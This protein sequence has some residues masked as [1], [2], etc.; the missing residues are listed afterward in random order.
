VVEGWEF[1][2]LIERVIE[3]TD[4]V[5]IIGEHVHLD[6]NHRALCPFHEEKNPSFCV[7]PKNAYFHCFGC[8]V[9]GDVIRF[10]QL[11]EGRTFW[12][13]LSYLA[14]RAGIPLP[15]LDGAV[16]AKMEEALEIEDVLTETA[17][18]Y[19]RMLTPEAR[20][21]LTK[22]R[23][24]TEETIARFR[25][26]YAA[27]GLRRHL[28]GKCAYP[29]E[30]CIRAGV[31]RKTKQGSVTDFFRN[32]II[33]P[34]IRQGRVVHLSG[35]SMDGSEPKYLRLPGQIRH[36]YNEDA[37]HN[38]EVCVVE[39]IVDCL[40]VAQAGLAAVA[41]LG[42]RSFKPE[43]VSKFRQCTRMDF[44]LDGD[45]AGKEGAL[46]AAQ[47]VGDKARIVMLPQGLDPNE[48]LKTHT[49]EDFAGLVSSAKDPV[50]FQLDLISPDTDK[51]ELP[52]R[53]MPVLEQ[54]SRIEKVKAEAHLYHDV[55]TRF[56]LKNRELDGYRELLNRLRGKNEEPARARAPKPAPECLYTALFDGLVDLVDQDGNPAF[57][58]KDGRK[59]SVTTQIEI[60]GVTYQPPPKVQIPWLLPRA[61]GVL[62]SNEAQATDHCRRMDEALYDDLVT[63]HKG[64]SE[65]PAEE[66]YD[67]VAAWVLHTYLLEAFQYSPI[68]CLFAVPERGK[69][70]TGK[71]IIYV[72]YRG[73]HA[74]SLRDAYIIRMAKNCHASIFFDVRNI[75]KK[76][77]KTGTEDILL[78]R[79][80]KGASVPRVLFPDRG[81]H[82]DTV[83]FEIFGPT[84]IGT[85]EEV[86]RILE[87]RAV[88]FY[89][90]EA[91]REYENDV[92]R[93]LSLPLKERLVALRARHLGHV[94]P[95]I[96][97]PAPGR[98]GQILKPLL[99]VIQLVNP[100]REEAFLALV[101]RLQEERLL[102]KADSFEA[103]ILTVME[104]L[105]ED[106]EKGILPVKTITDAFNMGRPERS[107]VTYQ[108]VGKLL[109]PMGFT[110][111]K[112][113]TGASAII[114]DE[115]KIHRIR[116]KYGLIQRSDTSDTSETPVRDAGDT[117]IPDDTDVCRSLF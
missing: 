33:F 25:I 41:V 53:L 34:N 24:L 22:E 23:D 6:R 93:E 108:R 82:K 100:K 64:I 9:G 86:H 61:D 88:P 77:V 116:D 28:T 95:D 13:A 96:H 3:Q 30:L 109:K 32:R 36:L 17:A 73:I 18:Y 98:L 56:G 31:L 20:T 63:Y 103:V 35:R 74:E 12:E 10:I 21:Y 65:L 49:K 113:R 117:D 75:W 90:P 71:G 114:W 78:H 50:R 66:Y 43:Y 94:F 79:F 85:N 29:L 62:G 27:G 47:L 91:R 2:N 26:G 67:L 69:T 39:G 97:K 16:R 111:C 57:L 80:E 40:S 76:A 52:G 7:N 104:S 105:R 92:T 101:R 14:Q 15:E 83:F 99:Q 1:R 107:Q 68:L 19:H 70:R 81:P 5:Q 72:A 102:E 58:V 4:I 87:T 54:L 11:F 38:D 45:K 8:G 110:K 84:V 60:E 112:T 51:T 44:C 59:L 115:D 46:K 89:M 55:K 106:V 37:L 48:Y 42:A